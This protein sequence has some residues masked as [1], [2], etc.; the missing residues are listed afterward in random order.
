VNIQDGASVSKEENFLVVK[1]PKG[2]LRKEFRH[3]RIKVKIDNSTVR[4]KSDS[5]RRKVG[6]VVGT[7]AAHLRNMTQGVK[8]GWEGRMKIVYSHFPV[9]VA[10]EGDR[11]VIQNF[12]GERKSRISKIA[13]DTKVDIKKDEIIVSGV[14]KEDVGQTCSNLELATK[15]KGRDKRIFQ[16]GIYITSKPQPPEEAG[17]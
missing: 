13:G 17:E 4:I 2:E 12:G 3:P 11:V 15:I 1:G 8:T 14:N 7:W 9:K 10:V 6:S 5:E 16:D